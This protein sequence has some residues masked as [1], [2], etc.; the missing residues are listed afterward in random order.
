MFGD[1]L[2][3]FDQAYP[4]FAAFKQHPKWIPVILVQIAEREK[5][6]FKVTTLSQFLAT[7]YLRGFER[8]SLVSGKTI[9]ISIQRTASTSRMPTQSR[10]PIPYLVF[11]RSRGR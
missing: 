4:K 1:Q 3:A 2:L 9:R 6:M 11:P 8:A 5:E 10:L 7:V